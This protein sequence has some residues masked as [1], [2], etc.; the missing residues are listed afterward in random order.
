MKIHWCNDCVSIVKVEKI[1]IL[2]SIMFIFWG[3][4]FTIVPFFGTVVGIPML[5]I[6][7]IWWY[8]TPNKCSRCEGRNLT[9]K[10]P[11]H[12]PFPQGREYTKDEIKKIFTREESGLVNKSASK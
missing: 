6:T 8:F 7:A 2:P 1:K 5:I 11:E 4:F 10:L 3:L 12:C 9:N